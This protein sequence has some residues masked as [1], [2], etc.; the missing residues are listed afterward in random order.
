MP[1][2]IANI[3]VPSSAKKAHEIFTEVDSTEVSQKLT[4]TFAQQG[5]EE[6]T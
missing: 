1:Y 2:V 4:W 3:V 6:R 5:D